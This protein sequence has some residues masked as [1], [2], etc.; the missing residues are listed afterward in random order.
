MRVRKIV[1]RTS[2]ES[3]ATDGRNPVNV[4]LG[5]L[6]KER[7]KH[8]GLSRK[9][10]ATMLDLTKADIRKY[11][12]GKIPFGADMLAV[13]RVALKI[14]VAHFTDQITGLVRSRGV[15]EWQR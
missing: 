9:G 10:L 4:R 6:M 14:S 2:G 11:E 5:Q 12:A 1:R 7:R 15:E 13:L 3:A 8:V